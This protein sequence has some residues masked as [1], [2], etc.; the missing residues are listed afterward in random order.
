[1]TELAIGV[2]RRDITCLAHGVGMLGYVKEGNVVEGVESPLYARATVLK[3]LRSG[4]K[5]ALASAELCFITEAVKLG[6]VARLQAEHPDM[7]Y[8]DA[9]VL[10]TAT[11]THSAPGGYSRYAFYNASVPGFVPEVWETVVTGLVAAI[12]EA[13][14]RA[15]PGRVRLA[16]GEVAPDLPVAFNRAITAHNANHDVQPKF[17]RHE[18]HLAVDREMTVLRLEAEDGAPL[19]L[20]DWF[21]VHATSIHNDNRLISGDNKGYAAAAAEAAFGQGFVATFCQGAAADVTP[22][23]QTFP[24]RP[25]P[26][27][28][29]ADDF[30]SARYHGGVQAEVALALY[31]AAGAS[32]A[33]EGPLDAAIMYVDMGDVEVDPAFAEG[34]TNCHT[35]P[36]AIGPRMLQGTAEG[37]GAP[38][39]LG[40][41][42]KLAAQAYMA[43]LRLGAATAPAPLAARLRRKLEAHGNKLLFVETGEGKVLG[44]RRAIQLLPGVDQVVRYM[45]AQHG[46]GDRGPWTPQVLPLQLVRLGG[47]AIAALP[48]ELTTQAGRRLKETIR[49]ALGVDRVLLTC[50]ANA[51]AGYVTTP[52]EYDLQAYEGASTHFGRWTLGAYQT[53]FRRLAQAMIA[54]PPERRGRLGL[55]APAFS[56]EELRRHVARPAR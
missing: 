43:R 12:A 54:Q 55:P 1:M 47:L 14:R 38:E 20:L 5:V 35:A 26:C 31:E 27:G 17:G 7:G 44:S 34:R 8:D 18:R 4:R 29:F 46:L 48:A 42:A 23:Y 45:Q 40:T 36:A 22:N 30:E 11:H 19:G 16:A 24:G 32:P 39:P 15:V 51:Y 9:S 2:A 56:E 37:P 41:A 6:V 49:E 3:D 13:D 52:E 10:L 28:K 33:L 50:Y 25:F 21:S 53:E